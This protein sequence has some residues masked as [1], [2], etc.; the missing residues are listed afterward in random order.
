MVVQLIMKIPPFIE[1]IIH[2]QFTGPYNLPNNLVHN[3]TVCFFK[4]ILILPSWPSIGLFPS[5]FQT[6]S[7]FHLSHVCY[8]SCLSNL[9]WFY[10]PNIWWEYKLWSSSMCGFLLP[11]VTF[12]LWFKYSP[13]HF[14]LKHFRSVF[15][16]LG[17]RLVVKTAHAF[18][19]NGICVCVQKYDCFSCSAGCRCHP[20]SLW[21]SGNV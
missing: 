19:C 3:L 4:T 14:I 9:P 12:L 8:M 18:S 7:M 2:Y 6:V 17:K 13:L 20:Q 5:D 16:S 11:T 10:H 15:F 1:A 21:Q